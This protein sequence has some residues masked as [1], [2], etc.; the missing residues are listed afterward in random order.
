MIDHTQQLTTR[1]YQ[2][3]SDLRDMLEMLV[4]AR[5]ATNDWHYPHVGELLWNFFMVLIHLDPAR[6]VRLWYDDARLVAFAILGEDPSFDFQVLPEYEWSGIETGAL[7]WAHALLSELRREDEQLWGGGLVAGARQDDPARLA[8]LEQH[9]FCYRG[10][11]AE[12]NM[13]RSLAVPIPDLIIP[14]GYQVRELA[15]AEIPDRAAVEREVWQPWT[16]GNVTGADYERLTHLPGYYR[17]L[18]VVTLTPGGLIASQ[19]NG[20]IDP[21]NRIGDFGPVGARPAYRQQGLTRLALLESLRRMRSFGM[22]RVC[23]STGITN[24]ASRN[25]YESVGFQVVNRY[26]DFVMPIG[27]IETKDTIDTK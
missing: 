23:V 6:H 21:L 8:F 11:F 18:D 10:T 22:D 16:V 24:T 4:Y 27:E 25:L 19:V 17:Q 12:V 20:W 7:S 2:D 9:G 5:R 13:L 1:Q 3:E 14:D 15:P 26:L